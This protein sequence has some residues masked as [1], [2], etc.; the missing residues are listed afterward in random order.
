MLPSS[1]HDGHPP[2]VRLSEELAPPIQAGPGY[3]FGLHGPGW[4]G[5]A[6]EIAS[7]SIS[8][9]VPVEEVPSSGTATQAG[10]ASPLLQGGV[11]EGGLVRLRRPRPWTLLWIKH[12]GPRFSGT[13]EGKVDFPHSRVYQ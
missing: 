13:A 4:A 12:C 2:I 10:T 5:G 3:A 9:I 11:F 6:P 1:I 7:G 8:D